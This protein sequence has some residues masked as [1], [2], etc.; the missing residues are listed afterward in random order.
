MAWVKLSVGTGGCG[1]RTVLFSFRTGL[2]ARRVPTYCGFKI[3]G[4]CHNITCTYNVYMCNVH[5]VKVCSLEQ[6]P[7]DNNYN[8]QI[9]WRFGSIV[10]LF[11][12]PI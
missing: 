6:M 12:V 10:V 7:A 5:I 2:P 1:A 11:Y 8:N 4:A 9:L 3:S